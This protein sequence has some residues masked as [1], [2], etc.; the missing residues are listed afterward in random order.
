M[1][2]PSALVAVDSA[3]ARGRIVTSR[4]RRATERGRMAAVASLADRVKEVAI[5]VDKPLVLPVQEAAML[6]HS[7]GPQPNRSLTHDTA[8]TA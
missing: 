4:S 2:V 6:Q 7:M 3:A 5:D 1:G 8:M